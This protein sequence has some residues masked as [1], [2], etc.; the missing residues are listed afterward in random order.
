MFTGFLITSSGIAVAQNLL[1]PDVDPNA[2]YYQPLEEMVNR[3]V[4]T[5][6]QDGSFG[7][8]DP[9]TRAQLMA[10]L[11]RYDQGLKE[12][13]ALRE[14][15]ETPENDLVKWE[16]DGYVFDYP[17][18]YTADERG[19][20][21]IEEYNRYLNPPDGCS[22]CHIPHYEVYSEMT[23]LNLEEYVTQDLEFP[24]STFEE[25]RNLAGIY[26]KEVTIGQNEFIKVQVNENF[27]TTSYYALKNGKVIRFRIYFEDRDTTELQEM[28]KSLTIE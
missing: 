6:Y 18:T 10:I 27:N 9:V 24:W 25:V 21:T 16:G 15:A 19:L 4:I 12:T 17:T 20:W 3:G 14:D 5:G 7:P 23:E 28:M 13:Y 22:I 26:P 11:S 2:Y 8:D 1:F